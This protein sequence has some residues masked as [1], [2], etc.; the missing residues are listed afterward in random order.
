MAD[1][2]ATEVQT[3]LLLSDDEKRI[4]EL[5]D[6]L[7]QLQLE[8][9]LLTAQKNYDPSTSL[10]TEN[11]SMEAAQKA[12]LD[13]RSR[14]VLRNQVAESIVAANPI[15]QAVHNGTKA[16]PIERDLLP[17]LEQRDQSSSV[18]S[19][20]STE[21]RGL[22][23]EITEVESQS[24]RLGRENVQLAAELLDLAEQTD[25]SKAE[26]INMDPERAAEISRLEDQVKLSRQ[27]WRVLKGTASAVVAGS[28]VDWS[29]DAELR[30]IVLDPEN[31]DEV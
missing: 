2:T 18:L 5:H 26:A 21:L 10:L 31:D 22:L 29:R 25:R 7:Q 9:A 11:E 23:D 3:P 20:Q 30:D 28:G 4:L 12:L 15:L 19:Q 6:R 13:S 14:Y 1:E 8:I 17:V 16:S 27:R 24:L